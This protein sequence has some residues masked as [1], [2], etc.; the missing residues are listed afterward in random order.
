[1]AEDLSS[2]SFIC[3]QLTAFL[4]YLTSTYNKQTDSPCTSQGQTLEKDCFYV[5]FF[6]W[7]RV[8]WSTFILI[9]TIVEVACIQFIIISRT[10]KSNKKR[11]SLHLGVHFANLKAF[12]SAGWSKIST[13]GDP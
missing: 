12:K 11:Q 9:T 5:T 4:T 6:L 7:P 13:F 10:H 2:V 1:M 8:K 3:I